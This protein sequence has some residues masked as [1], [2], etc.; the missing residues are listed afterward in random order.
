MRHRP[1]SRA[2]LSRLWLLTGT[3][4]IPWN[5]LSSAFAPGLLLPPFRVLP[6]LSLSYTLLSF[7]R[8]R[9]TSRTADFWCSA[10]CTPHLRSDLRWPLPLYSYVSYFRSH[11]LEFHPFLP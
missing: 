9:S 3:D 8:T 10:L 2:G 1:E 4:S 11:D 5:S 6:D 7:I